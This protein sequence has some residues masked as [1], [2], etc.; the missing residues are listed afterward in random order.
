MHF[1]TNLASSGG[2][3]QPPFPEPRQR[4]F[5]RNG[6]A[7]TFLIVEDDALIALDLEAI[8]EQAGGQIIGMAAV[9]AD[10]ERLATSLRPDVVLMDVRLR[11]DR[12]GITSASAIQ[13]LVGAPVVFVTGNEDADTVAR[14]M[15][16][17]GSRPV[18]KPVIARDLIEAVLASL[19]RGM[20]GPGASC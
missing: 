9:A 8:V 13:E 15:A 6:A 20:R 10:A 12:D 14:I 3:P 7:L 1:A 2:H 18:K 5:V 16:I 11:G 4:P 17:S 19:E